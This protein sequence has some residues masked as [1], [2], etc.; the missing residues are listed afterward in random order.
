MWLTVQKYKSGLLNV[1]KEGII[2]LKYSNFDIESYFFFRRFE[3]V[4]GKKIRQQTC[5]HVL[6]YSS[7]LPS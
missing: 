1:I 4:V 2:N 3:V 7:L 5:P 6:P